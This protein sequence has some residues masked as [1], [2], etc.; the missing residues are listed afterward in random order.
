MNNSFLPQKKDLPS[1]PYPLHPNQKGLSSLVLLFV[2]VLGVFILWETN[3][4]IGVYT[5]A[6]DASPVAVNN[7]PTT[8]YCKSGETDNCN[9]SNDQF[10]F[11]E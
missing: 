8:T 10:L 9:D 1:T 5:T 4:Y 11:T 2:I 7:G 6:P 3:E